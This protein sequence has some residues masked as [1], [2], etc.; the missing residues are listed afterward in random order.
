MDVDSSIQVTRGA[1]G[2]TFKNTL[3][4]P[5]GAANRYVRIGRYKGTGYM[6]FE[7]LRNISGYSGV[8]VHA[9]VDLTSTTNGF[10]VR[11]KQGDT[12][13]AAYTRL[14][15][16]VLENDM[17]LEPYLT[18]QADDAYI[19]ITLPWQG[20]ITI[21]DIYL[22]MDSKVR[23]FDTMEALITG[24]AGAL[25][26]NVHTVTNAAEFV[27]A[28][29]AV[30]A[31]GAPSIINVAGT[32]SY[33]DWV[34]AGQNG[35]EASISSS[36]RDLSIIGV[37]TQGLLDGVGLAVQGE[38]VIIQNL[39]VRY[40]LARDAIQVN[41]GRYVKIDHCTLYNEPFNINPDKDKFDELIS[42][43]N[44]AMYVIVSWN[45][46]YNTHKTILVGSND[47]VDALP[48]RKVIFHHN[49]FHDGGSRHPLYRGGYAHVYNNYFEDISSAINVRTNAKMLIENNYFSNVDGAIGYWFD[50]TNPAGGY[51]VNNNI[52]VNVGG[53]K[54]T[55]STIDIVFDGDYQYT[56][57]AVGD[58]PAIVTAG[59]GVGKL[60]P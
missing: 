13:V 24:G 35:R 48:D 56:L 10:Y 34:A 37:G 50:T 15:A 49:W 25:P 60:S 12:E 7:A 2:I 11:M 45:E 57:D 59:A 20:Q 22:Y 33:E 40:V 39:T 6:D 18:N 21:K 26:E 5:G 32:V 36:M 51:E 4:F 28:L 31:A 1:D 53:D 27:A 16:G 29:A 23:G 42:I 8:V 17:L 14:S 38:N 52:F 19:E 44:D 58:V 54:P 46:I 47:G 55:T 41:N 43:K 30:R 3:T 9:D